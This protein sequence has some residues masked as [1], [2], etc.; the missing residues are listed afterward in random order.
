MANTSDIRNIVFLGHAGSGKTSLVEAILHKTGK[1]NRLGTIEDKSTVCDYDDDEKSH[2]Y[3]I[4]AA[5]A[6]TEYQGKKINMIDAPGYPSFIGAAFQSVGAA[7]IAAV[8]ISASSGIEVNTRKH[9]AAA[10]EAGLA[11]IIVV[12][13]IDADNVDLEE[14]VGNI[15]ET[16]G[17][18][19]RCANLPSSDKA[20]VLD[21]VKGEEGDAAFKSVSDCH[22]N[23]ME[24]V[25]EADDDLM[26]AYLGGEDVSS[27]QIASVFSKA[28][29]TGSI[30]PIVFTNARE[31]AGIEEMLELISVNCPSPADMQPRK[32]TKN[33]KETDIKADP[34]APLCGLV[35]RV[36][37]D[38]KSHMKYSYIRIISGTIKSDTQMQRNDDKKTLRPGHILVPQGG[39][40]EETDQGVAGEIICLAKIEELKYGDMI[41]DGSMDGC[42]KLPTMPKPMFALALEP[43]SRGDETKIGAALE[44]LCEADPCITA[45]HNPETKELVINGMDDLHLKIMLERLEANY[46]VKVNTKPPKIPYRETIGAKAEGHYRHKK[47][48]GGAGQFGEVYLRVEPGDRDQDPSLITSWDIF[49]GS[50]PGQFESPIIKGIQD[51][52]D[53]GYLAGFPMQDVK[54]S[55]Y[56]GKHHPVDSKEVAFRA[57]GKG[58]FL[59]ALSKAKPSLLE[60]LVNME[61]TV[62]GEFMG[63]ITGD[64]AGRRGRIQGQ[65]VM[66]GGMMVIK[67][68]VPLAEVASYNSQLKSVTGGQG[69]YSMELSHYEPVPP[70]VQQ[71]IIDKYKKEQEE[72][73]S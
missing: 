29:L 2:G 1:T 5:V 26:E 50:I 28:M 19:C 73:N 63:D 34:S 23:L 51:V 49:G 62:P 58:A 47:Q 64:I 55:I 25:I 30:T 18:Q 57:A 65:D 41:H 40:A 36:G 15:Q 13:K 27:E 61:I 56:D 8:V 38:P 12:N 16:F 24:S 21:C 46:K 68:V 60:P 37:F 32:I 69:S 70:N 44:K 3:S 39:A 45:G 33:E 31:Q 43:A 72:D 53:S 54:V 22:T 17:A 9:Y 20:R 52:M 14:L 10:E 4:Q 35:F 67:A 7:D 59:D 48:S 66:P 11:K 6:H 71:Q 42:L